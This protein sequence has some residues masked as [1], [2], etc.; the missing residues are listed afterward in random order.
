MAFIYSLWLLYAADLRFV[1]LG[2]LLVMPGMIIYIFTRISANERIFN[3]FEWLIAAIVTVSSIA[4]LW[5]ILTG[6]IAL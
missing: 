6:E 5:L 3:A 2:T 1:L 4:G